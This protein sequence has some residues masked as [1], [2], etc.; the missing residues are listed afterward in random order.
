MTSRSYFGKMNSILGSVVP[1]AMFLQFFPS[2]GGFNKDLYFYLKPG[3]RV[4]WSPSWT[5]SGFGRLQHSLKNGKHLVDYLPW[6]VV[7]VREDSLAS[8]KCSCVRVASGLADKT[9]HGRIP[10]FARGWRWGSWAGCVTYQSNET[11][12]LFFRPLE[13][14]SS[15]LM[16]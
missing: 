2:A 5:I 15:V 12:L 13:E 14:K 1:L 3:H 8:S 10:F 9:S 4:K 6:G 7:G 16:C 11:N